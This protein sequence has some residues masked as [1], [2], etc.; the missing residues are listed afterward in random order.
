MNGSTATTSYTAIHYRPEI[1]PV[2]IKPSSAFVP[3]T[4][5]VIYA[6]QMLEHIGITHP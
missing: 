3:C 5:A 6:L 1:R 4:N 2:S